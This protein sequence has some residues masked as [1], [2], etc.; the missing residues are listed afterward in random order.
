MTDFDE[1]LYDHDATFLL[2]DFITT[3]TAELVVI[4]TLSFVIKILYWIFPIFWV[5]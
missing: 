2:P 3:L 5:V 1:I 4:A